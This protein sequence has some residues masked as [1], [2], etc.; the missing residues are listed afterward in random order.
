MFCPKE[1]DMI[2]GKR[3]VYGFFVAVL[4]ILLVAQPLSAEEPGS[5]DQ[6]SRPSLEGPNFN[7]NQMESDRADKDVLYDFRLLK[8]Y[9][10]WKAGIRENYGFSF[11]IDYTGAYLTSDDNLPAT[12]D[13]ASGGMARFFGSWEMLGRGTDTTG[14]LNFKVDHRHRYSDTAPSEFSVGSLGNVGAML[15]T[16]NNEGWRLTNLFWRQNWNNGEVVALAGFLDATDFVDIYALASPWLHFMNLAFS[17]GAGT[18][19]LPGDAALGAAVGG[20]LNENL[21]IMVSFEDANSEPDDPF[22]GFDTFYNDHEY[23][24]HIEIGWTTSKDRAYLDNIHLTMWQ[25]DKREKAGVDDGWG[26]VLSFTHYIG[27]KWMPYIRAGYAKDGGSLLER[28]VS[29]GFG[30]QPNPIGATAGNLLG[31]GANWGKPNEAVFGSGLDDQYA[32]EL[33]YRLQVTN[34]LAMTPDIQFLIDPA[35]H[36]DEDNLWV[37]GLRARVAL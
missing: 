6:V 28:S 32:F 23:F 15:G 10:E 11:G 31:F 14:A 36:P 7:E 24:K 17:T 16:F 30:Y 8:P 9:F 13:H 22:E 33:F 19:S 29:T 12:D 2:S 21:Y 35:L 1:N 27:D 4:L 3:K 25:V 5:S 18:I 34:E 37:F 20:W 26:G